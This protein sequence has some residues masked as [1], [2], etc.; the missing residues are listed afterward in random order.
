MTRRGE[1]DANLYLRETRITRKPYPRVRDYRWQW[2]ILGAVVVGL[3]VW[4][5]MQ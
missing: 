1:F 5:W 2:A 3:A 4:G